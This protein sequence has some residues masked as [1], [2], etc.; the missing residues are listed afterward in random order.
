M[1]RKRLK[2]QSTRD[3]LCPL[4]PLSTL[5]R[6]PSATCT[7]DTVRLGFVLSPEVQGLGDD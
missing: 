4:L 7:Q 3:R 1:G 5:G 2:T 6:R